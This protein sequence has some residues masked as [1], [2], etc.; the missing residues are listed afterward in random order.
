MITD[1]K[2]D[3]LKRQLIEATVVGVEGTKTLMDEVYALKEEIGNKNAIISNHAKVDEE[4]GHMRVMA[5][6]LEATID[7]YRAYITSLQIQNRK[8]QDDMKVAAGELLV[9][10]P[11][12][13]TDL[14]RVLS[15]NVLLR[16]ELAEVRE[17]MAE[18]CMRLSDQVAKM[19]KQRDAGY[20]AL[21]RLQQEYNRLEVIC[22][23]WQEEN[24]NLIS[25]V[26]RLNEET[27]LF[28]IEEGR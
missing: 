3:E 12:S 14:A 6:S 7:E 13:E 17:E 2:L 21:E 20:E 22:S 23:E 8:A 11:E 19:M 9:D 15:A 26:E 24:I 27:G 25:Q 4:L 1:D 16:R 18:R 28:D 10:M 5:S